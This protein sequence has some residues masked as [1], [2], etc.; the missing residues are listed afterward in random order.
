M[1]V[2]L[3]KYSDAIWYDSTNMSRL[4]QILQHDL[5][6]FYKHVQTCHNHAYD[7]IWYDSQTFPDMSYVML[8]MR[9]DTILK[10]IQTWQNAYDT[11]YYNSQTYPDMS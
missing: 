9:F 6:W 2:D 8:L 4:V 10:H 3:E 11:I 5:I 1:V 7:A